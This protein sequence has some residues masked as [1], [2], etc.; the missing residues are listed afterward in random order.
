MEYI[1]ED[2]HRGNRQQDWKKLLL[3]LV[4]LLVFWALVIASSIIFVAT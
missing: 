3:V 4:A 1:R 2:R